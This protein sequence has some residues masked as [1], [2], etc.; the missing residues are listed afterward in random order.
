MDDLGKTQQR[1]YAV[2]LPAVSSFYTK[3]LD[4]IV[5]KVPNESRVPA[6]FEHGNEGL[7]FLKDKDTLFSLPIWAI[8]GGACSFRYCKEPRR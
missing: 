8:L 5:N 4:K 7:D 1:D 6:G 3:Q 2:Y